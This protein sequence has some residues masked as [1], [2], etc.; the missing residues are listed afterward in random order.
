VRYWARQA[1]E[2]VR[3]APVPIDLE[4]DGADIQAAVARWLYP[5]TTAPPRAPATRPRA[6]AEP[7]ED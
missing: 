4:Q 7:E 3:G 1:L 6:P 2:R 5:G